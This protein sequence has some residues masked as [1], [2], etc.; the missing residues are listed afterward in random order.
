MGKSRPSAGRK[1]S[2]NDHVKLLHLEEFFCCDRHMEPNLYIVT[3]VSG[4]GKTTVARNLLE[5]GE[6]AFDSK[7]NP[8][9]YYFVDSEGI[10]ADSVQLDNDAWRVRFKWSLNEKMLKKL[11]EDHQNAKRVFLCGR[12]NLFQYWHKAKVVFLLKVDKDTLISR[13]NN[14][15]RDNLFASDTATQQHLAGNLYM[16]Q[17][18]ISG[19][20][21]INI[22]ANFPIDDVVNQ[23]LKQAD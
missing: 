18:K 16:M 11:L 23:I 19:K 12:A 2:N 14:V 4:S 5:R 3:G 13:L 15:T 9:L 7:I 6:I 1:P 8:N 20:G 17:D 22:D 10:V 21:A